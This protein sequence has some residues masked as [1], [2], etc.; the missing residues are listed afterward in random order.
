M[1][2]ENDLTYSEAIEQVMLN[3]NYLAPLK[4][5]YEE[6]WRYKDRTK[7]KGKTPNYT[8]QERVQRDPRFTRIGV[9]VY[10]LTEHLD[11]IQ[12]PQEPRKLKEKSEFQHIRIQG[13]LLE[14]GTLE[15]YDT[16][17][18][19]RSKNFDGKPLG[20]ICSLNTCPQFTFPD[21]IEQTVRHID[22]I[23]FNERR[24][25]ALAFEVEHSTDF[26]SS[27]IKFCEL[28]DFMTDFFVVAPT[29]RQQKYTMEIHKSAFTAIAKRC[30]F[31]SYEEVEEYYQ[32]LLKY[33]KVRDI[34]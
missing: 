27:L 8:I 34:F 12:K 18:P 16:Y 3:N 7:I 28:Q 29:A 6:I 1:E 17:T 13:M 4:L 14:I 9:G 30:K 21:I 24:F 15:N 23:L 32:G 25:P 19:D 33:S 22:V 2:K 10:A 5:I 26:R 11:K 31:R 20:S